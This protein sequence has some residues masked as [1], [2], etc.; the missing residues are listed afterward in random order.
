MVAIKA[1]SISSCMNTSLAKRPREGTI[2]FYSSLIRQHLEYCARLQLTERNG[3][4]EGHQY[5]QGVQYLPYAMRLMG[6]GSLS[7]EGGWL[8]GNPTA[9]CQCLRADYQGGRAWHLTERTVKVQGA[10]ILK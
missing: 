10:T 1:N 5:R 2:P 4:A 7:L 8:W 6:L 3:S 9:A